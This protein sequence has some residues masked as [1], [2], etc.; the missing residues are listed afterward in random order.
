M[1]RPSVERV[2]SALLY[3]GYMLYPYR[4]SA[5]KNRQ[6]FNFGVLYPREYSDAQGGNDPCEM[7]TECLLEG[8]PEARIDITVRFLHLFERTPTQEGE[9]AWHDA[10]EREVT[11]GATRSELL[12]TPRMLRFTFPAGDASGHQAALKGRVD[13]AAESAALGVD[14]V[15]VAIAN[16]TPIEPRA[17]RE[18]AMLRS[19]VST[20]TILRATAGDYISLTDPPA[21]LKDSAA[22]CRNVGTWPV[23]AGEG[24]ARDTVLSSPI[25]LPDFPSI[26]PESQADFFDGTEIDE[27]LSLRILTLTDEEKQEMV[28]SDPRARLLLERTEAF[29]QEQLL[30][31]HG[32]LREIRALEEAP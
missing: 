24:G 20:H 26:A 4:R 2:A 12:R 11:M 9:P 19:L 15:R 8:D 30:R 5:L 1:K 14:R 18:E 27:M 6:R 25:I 28:A 3:E 29:G 31:M 21:E 32:V 13:L 17:S 16:L 22:A 10:M 23:L 7:L